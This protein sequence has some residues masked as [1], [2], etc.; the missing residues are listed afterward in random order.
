[1]RSLPPGST[2][3]LAIECTAKALT[4]ALRTVHPPAAKVTVIG[5]LEAYAAAGVRPTRPTL[6]FCTSLDR[7]VAATEPIG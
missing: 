1:M 6:A 7:S 4:E 5:E 2:T 3:L